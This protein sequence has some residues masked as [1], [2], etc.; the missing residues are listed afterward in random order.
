MI[1]SKTKPGTPSSAGGVPDWTSFKSRCFESIHEQFDFADRK[2]YVLDFGAPNTSVLKVLREYDVIYSCV[3]LRKQIAETLNEQSA[4]PEEANPG[5]LNLEFDFMQFQSYLEQKKEGT[6][7]GAVLLWD[8]VNY[9]SRA[10][11][12]NLMSLISPHCQT[13]TMLYALSWM[14]SQMPSAP[15][16]FDLHENHELY[17]QI[18]HEQMT[19]ESPAYTA[20]TINSLVPSFTMYRLVA[21]GSGI[22]EILLRFDTYKE[23]PD[24]NLVIMHSSVSGLN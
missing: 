19:L 16:D 22:Q 8:L 23:P 18:P 14:R 11:I 21:H 13:G 17:Y 1:P 4:D 2:I 20:Q 6:V 9:L 7:F 24:E 5:Q 3:N 12:V 10:S 15:V